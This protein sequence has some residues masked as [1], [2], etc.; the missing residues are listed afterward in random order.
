MRSVHRYSKGDPVGFRVAKRSAHPGPLAE[1]I[2]PEPLSEDYPYH[3]DKYWTVADARAD[4]QVVVRTR[5]GKTHVLRADHPELRPA[6]LWERL[7]K[8]GRFPDLKKLPS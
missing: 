4:G 8:K 3:V 2:D 5:R 7:F 1:Q 6:N